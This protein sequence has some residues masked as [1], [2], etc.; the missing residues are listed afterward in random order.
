MKKLFTFIALAA[1]GLLIAAKS[2]AQ[3]YPPPAY[4]QPAPGYGNPGYGA[5][6]YATPPPAYGAQA[7][8]DVDPYADQDM[9][10]DGYPSSDGI[11]YEDQFPGYVYYDFPVW[12]GHY[13]DYWYYAHW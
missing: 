4:A 2:D 10:P 5:P 12:N 1:G 13:R 11:I 9:G 3:D 7:P 6:Q 8:V